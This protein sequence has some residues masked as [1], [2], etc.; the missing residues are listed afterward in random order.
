[1][2]EAVLCS[3]QLLQVDDG[4]RS[5]RVAPLSSPMQRHTPAGSPADAL[6][7][8]NPFN[9]CAVHQAQLHSN[10]PDI[11]GDASLGSSENQVSEVVGTVTCKH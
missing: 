8:P 2:A 1:M 10:L 4:L 5:V 7:F 11:G 9:S 3:Q 6:Q